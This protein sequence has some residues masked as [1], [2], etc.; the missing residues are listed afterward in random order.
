MPNLEPS[1]THS[2]AIYPASSC[3]MSLKS[4]QKTALRSQ[5]FSSMEI[6]RRTFAAF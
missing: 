2:Q 3:C 5:E 6:E 1:L 4:K